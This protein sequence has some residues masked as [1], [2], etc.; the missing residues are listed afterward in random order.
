M[1][2]LTELHEKGSTIV[3]ITHDKS[4]ADYAHRKI[5]IVDGKI[6]SDVMT[7]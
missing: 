4:I 2:L 5:R 3:V 6:V 1:E 7:K